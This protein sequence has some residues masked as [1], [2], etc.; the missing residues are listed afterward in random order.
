MQV[1]TAKLEQLAGVYDMLAASSNS[2]G[3]DISTAEYRPY[4]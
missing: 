1:D 3:N 4:H 2:E